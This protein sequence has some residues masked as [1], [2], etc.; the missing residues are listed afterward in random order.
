MSAEPSAENATQ[1][2]PK[3]APVDESKRTGAWKNPD[4]LRK[5]AMYAHANTKARSGLLIIRP[6][7]LS[8]P[9]NAQPAEIRCDYFKGNRLVSCLCPEDD[10]DEPGSKKKKSKRPKY[11]ESIVDEQEANKV[12]QLLLEQ[13][14]YFAMTQKPRKQK[15]DNPDILELAPAGR[16]NYT[17]KHVKGDR[18][19][20]DYYTWITE[21]DQTTS[22]IMTGFL[23]VAFLLIT[24]FP[25]WPNF[26]KL[27]LWYLSV[28]LLIAIFT[29]V[30]V[31]L[32][33]FLFVW[34]FGYEFWILPNLFDESLTFVESFKPFLSFEPTGPGQLWWRMAVFAAFGGIIYWAH[35]QPTDF[36]EFLKSNRQFVDD[37]YEGNLL[38][39]TSQL[40]RD[41]LDKIKVPT[42]EDLLS[43]L[44][45]ERT[46]NDAYEDIIGEED[47]MEA[48]A[49]VDSMLD[50]LFEA[51]EMDDND[52]DDLDD[53]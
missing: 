15:G 48:E 33:L 18:S 47:P 44:E 26:M 28:T 10:D 37:L 9:A 52:L 31:R 5:I 27:G 11:L 23:M 35:T 3:K 21:G 8:V 42:I 4:N 25:I 19:D 16:W 40:Y 32:F 20:G 50:S 29:L 39:D 1:A 30:I 46:E 17:K 34:V 49:D 43:D 51:D 24:F 38:S 45:E 41:E 22:T 13:S 14:E 53:D 6:G 2:V 7:Q 36:D 12:A